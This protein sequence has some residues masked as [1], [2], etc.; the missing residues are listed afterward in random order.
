MVVQLKT[1][2]YLRRFAHSSDDQKSHADGS[3]TGFRISTFSFLLL[4][5]KSSI[6]PLHCAD[7]V[8]TLISVPSF[9]ENVWN[10]TQKKNSKSGKVISTDTELKQLTASE[11]YVLL[12]NSASHRVASAAAVLLLL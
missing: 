11:R 7:V 9:I 10:R 4:Y 5:L 8:P 3:H 2:S 12:S 1:F 6:V